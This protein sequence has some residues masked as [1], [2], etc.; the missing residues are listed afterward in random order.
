MKPKHSSL[1][2]PIDDLREY[3]IAVSVREHNGI[4]SDPKVTCRA[5]TVEELIDALESTILRIRNV[6]TESAFE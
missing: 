6:K 3:H 2:E 4:D 1:Y 5:P